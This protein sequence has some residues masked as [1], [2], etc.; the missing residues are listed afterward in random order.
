MFERKKDVEN[1]R[2]VSTIISILPAVPGGPPPNSVTEA[3][4]REAQAYI[5]KSNAESAV[6]AN[7]GK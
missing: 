5:T 4:E 3:F 6:N 7:K 1:V 2:D